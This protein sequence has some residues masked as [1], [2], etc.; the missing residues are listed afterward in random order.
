VNAK[1]AGSILVRQRVSQQK[2][3]VV[4]H[5]AG[6]VH[7]GYSARAK[8]CTSGSSVVLADSLAIKIAFLSSRPR[9]SNRASAAFLGSL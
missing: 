2:S 9:G 8:E 7:G 6:A 1:G 4:P 5:V 3:L